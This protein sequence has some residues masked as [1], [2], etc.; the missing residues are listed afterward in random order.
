MMHLTK[1]TCRRRQNRS[2]RQ[3]PFSFIDSVNY[4][5]SFSWIIL[6]LYSCITYKKS[7]RNQCEYT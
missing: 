7:Q 6:R 2:S 3:R 1:V 4:P 5:C